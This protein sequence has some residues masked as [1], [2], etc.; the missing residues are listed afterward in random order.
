MTRHS[1]SFAKTTTTKALDCFAKRK[2]TKNERCTHTERVRSE[3]EKWIKSNQQQNGAY[4]SLTTTNMCLCCLCCWCCCCCCCLS[5]HYSLHLQLNITHTWMHTK[6][7]R[8][9]IQVEHLRP[10]LGHSKYVSSRALFAP[11]P[12]SLSLSP[13][14]ALRPPPPPPPP[15]LLLLPSA[16]PLFSAWWFLAQARDASSKSSIYEYAKR[17]E[18]TERKLPGR[19]TKKKFS[20]SHNMS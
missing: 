17:D 10:P 3:R 16:S 13:F 19:W 6:S 2:D 18:T 15:L 7:K 5:F 20:D 8:I 14:S 9:N 11:L 1:K 12:A 4:E